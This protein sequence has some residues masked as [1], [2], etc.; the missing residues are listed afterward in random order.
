MESLEKVKSN[1]LRLTLVELEQICPAIPERYWWTEGRRLGDAGYR[2]SASA[3]K[4]AFDDRPGDFAANHAFW[5]GVLEGS[6]GFIFND[7]KRRGAALAR[8]EGR[9]DYRWFM[10]SALYAD[11]P[12]WDREPG[13]ENSAISTCSTTS[14]M[15]GSKQVRN[16]VGALWP[17]GSEFV[18]KMTFR[19]A[20]EAIRAYSPNTAEQRRRKKAK[21]LGI[22]MA[23]IEATITPELGP[24][25]DFSK[26]R[27]DFE[28]NNSGG[29][30][31]A[32]EDVL[33]T[34]MSRVPRKRRS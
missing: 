7:S 5:R 14:T 9:K 13:C 15:I 8:L 4:D 24:R 16:L 30:R 34:G 1:F 32:V 2:N 28:E 27:P 29:K 11:F 21:I 22:P 25:P 33:A 20:L 17:T 23:T 19:R 12:T 10:L 18:A 31:K 3:F 6:L 26:Y